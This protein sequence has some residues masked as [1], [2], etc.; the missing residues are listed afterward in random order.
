MVQTPNGLEC[1][2]QSLPF[3]WAFDV[4][5]TGVIEGA[6]TIK[7]DEFHRVSFET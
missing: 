7:Y 5:I 1:A 6:I 3:L 2:R 4:L